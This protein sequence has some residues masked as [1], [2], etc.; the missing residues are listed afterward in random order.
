MPHVLYNH[1]THSWDRPDGNDGWQEIAAKDC[2]LPQFGPLFRRVLP[3][4]ALGAGTTFTTVI[5]LGL[6]AG[7]LLGVS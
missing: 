1:L 6:I 7:L 4:L 5:L 2:E 3:C